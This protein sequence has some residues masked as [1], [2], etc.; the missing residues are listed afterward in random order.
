[1]SHIAIPYA[2][3]LSRL[4]CRH[5][6]VLYGLRQL[7]HACYRH[8]STHLLKDRELEPTAN[9]AIHAALPIDH[10]SYDQEHWYY[11]DGIYF[12]YAVKDSFRTP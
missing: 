8:P 5:S 4:T 12:R 7:S 11:F 9:R 6:Q 10:L 2:L 1:V 3:S